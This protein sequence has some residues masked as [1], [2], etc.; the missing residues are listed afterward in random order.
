M[1]VAA[2]VPQYLQWSAEGRLGV[3]DPVLAAQTPQKPG[4]LLGLTE[5]SSR[6]GVAEL[7]PP[8]QPFQAVDE[9]AAKETSQ[10]LEW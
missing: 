9:L 2:E 8:I 5:Y 1:R 3:Y 7:L 4:K 6:S 10:R